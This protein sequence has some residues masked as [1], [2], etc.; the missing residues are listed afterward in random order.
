MNEL[1]ALWLYGS[2]AR[3]DSD[4]W[5]DVDLLLISNSEVVEE[6]LGAEETLRRADLHV[7]GI[8]E[9]SNWMNEPS[10]V[11]ISRYTWNEIEEMA[12]YGS[13]FLHHL[14]LEGKSLWEADA[15]KGRLAKLLKQL[16]PYERA[17]TDLIAF[18]RTIADV[19]DSLFE[20]GSVAFE[21]IVLATVLRHSCILGCYLAGDPDFGRTSPVEKMATLL[22][23]DSQVSRSVI[24]LCR[25]RAFL[26]GHDSGTMKISAIDPVR[27][28]DETDAL[29]SM[30]RERFANVFR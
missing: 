4:S 20:G 15:V 30:V 7:A 28:C 8:P 6:D 12:S 21:M 25:Y 9:L 13:L 23:L 3:H 5:S 29:V 24:R 1:N 19:R 16:P 2:Y 18:R 14:R 27:W 26:D 22:A 10:K 17:T 11:S